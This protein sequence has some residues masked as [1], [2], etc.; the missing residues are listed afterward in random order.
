MEVNKLILLTPLV[1]LTACATKAVPIR[2]EIQTVQ[3]NVPA[4][5]PEKALGDELINSRPVPLRLTKRPS[6]ASVRSAQ[7]QAQLGKYEA[8]GGWADKV[9]AALKRCQTN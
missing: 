6:D 7:S 5:C 1:F 8:E 3:V 2:T 4:P 9:V